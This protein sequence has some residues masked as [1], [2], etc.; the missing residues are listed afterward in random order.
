MNTR[1][2]LIEAIGTQPE[3]LLLEVQHYLEFLVTRQG[4]PL[5][6]PGQGD[7]WPE[8]YFERTAGAFADEPFERPVESPLEQRD[9]W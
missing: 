5:A 1:E 4:A 9:E 3:P 8:R 6:A 7:R 2:A